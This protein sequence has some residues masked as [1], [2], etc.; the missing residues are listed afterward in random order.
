MRW[1]KKQQP[2]DSA[3]PDPPADDGIGKDDNPANPP[4]AVA[5]P[6]ADQITTMKNTKGALSIVSKTETQLWQA[7]TDLSTVDVVSGA[8]SFSQS[9]ATLIADATNP[10]VGMPP[11]V[12]PF[13]QVVLITDQGVFALIW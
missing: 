9:Q 11:L 12:A 10:A 13:N 7:Y 4:P 5:L 3:P 6:T 1:L 2:S 8:G